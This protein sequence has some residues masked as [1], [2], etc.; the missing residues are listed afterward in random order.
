MAS[1]LILSKRLFSALSMSFLLLI[2]CF[3][4]FFCTVPLAAFDDDVDCTGSIRLVKRSFL[5][6]ACM[7][8]IKL[9]TWIQ[10]HKGETIKH[11]TIQCIWLIHSMKF[12]TDENKWHTSLG[13]GKTQMQINTNIFSGLVKSLKCVFWNLKYEIHF[14]REHWKQIYTHFIATQSWTTCP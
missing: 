3:C 10:Y 9:H 8:K 5:W 4:A 6:P 14:G 1:C 7:K 11:H 2:L 13:K 12:D